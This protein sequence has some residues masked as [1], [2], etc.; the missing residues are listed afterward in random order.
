MV[1]FKK[2]LLKS[3]RWLMIWIVIPFLAALI[4]LSVGVN[5]AE[6]KGW[7][8][9]AENVQ[10]IN[11]DE[12]SNK[13]SEE[14]ISLEKS[15]NEDIENMFLQYLNYKKMP[16][17]LYAK[18][19]VILM[20][21]DN[22]YFTN[23]ISKFNSKKEKRK[24]NFVVYQSKLISNQKVATSNLQNNYE[25]FINTLIKLHEKEDA[26]LKHINKTTTLSSKQQKTLKNEMIRLHVDLSNQYGRVVE[27]YHL[28]TNKTAYLPY[29]D[30]TNLVMEEMKKK[31]ES[32]KVGISSP[33]SL[34]KYTKIYN[35]LK[36]IEMKEATLSLDYSV[37]EI[38]TSNS[39]S[40]L[41]NYEIYLESL[42]SYQK[43]LNNKKSTWKD[44][45][46]NDNS[47]IKNEISKVIDSYTLY[48]ENRISHVSK[49]KDYYK[50]EKVDTVLYYELLENEILI[51]DE[52]SKLN[53][54]LENF[55][56][57]IEELKGGNLEEIEITEQ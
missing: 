23:Q 38:K 57:L 49:V 48:L 12:L 42:N 44:S 55:E 17:I 25:Q 33:E 8:F 27:D 18:D 19:S 9:E 47:F 56:K 7:L 21:Y 43:E 2:F 11:A 46:S 5:F 53:L 22:D 40:N 54:T 31:E 32:L 41:K 16:N 24:D 15:I 10:L 14:L 30:E 3:I 1:D 26:L 28:W 20:S 35:E 51:N 6:E 37:E 36:S 29:Y 13:K 45:L 39:P 50:N 4:I 52:K 34:G